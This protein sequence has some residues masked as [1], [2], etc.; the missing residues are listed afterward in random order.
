VGALLGGFTYLFLAGLSAGFGD[1]VGAIAVTALGVYVTG[2]LHE[3]G[4]ADTVDA[5]GGATSKERALEIFKDSRIGSYGT[6]ALV[7][8]LLL[9]AALFVKLGV[10]SL[11]PIVLYGCI[12]R[13]SPLYLMTYVPHANA[14]TS[15]WQS[16]QRLGKSRAYVGTLVAVVLAVA[17]SLYEPG[18][19]LRLGLAFVVTALVALGFARLGMR[20]INGITGDLLG[21]SEQVAELSILLVFAWQLS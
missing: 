1:W 16:M 20:R 12:A 21:A 15:K 10:S 18:S 8:S 9:R 14:A 17:L 4:L 5:L 7:L 2:A 13:L 3:D 11:I 6:C 19:E